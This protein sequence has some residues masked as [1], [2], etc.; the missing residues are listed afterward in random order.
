MTKPS[1][2]S[3]AQWVAEWLL[4]HPDDPTQYWPVHC[5]PKQLLREDRERRRM[6]RAILQYAE[7]VEGCY[8]D[9]RSILKIA[10]RLAKR[11]ERHE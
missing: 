8:A 10:R 11:K 4:A 5:R 2:R 9:D 7:P 1:A 6:E 3:A